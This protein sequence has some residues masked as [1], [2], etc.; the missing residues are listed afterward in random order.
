M[1]TLVWLP[2]TIGQLV[3]RPLS[4]T[5]QATSTSNPTSQSR[6]QESEFREGRRMIEETAAVYKSCKSYQ[7]EGEVVRIDDMKSG[8]RTTQKSFKTAFIRPDRF[9]FEHRELDTSLRRS[10]IFSNGTDVRTWWSHQPGEMKQDNRK[11]A[12]A[13]TLWG[14]GA[15]VFNMAAL[16]VPDE[17]DG[18]NFKRLENI[19]FSDQESSRGVLYNIIDANDGPLTSMRIWINADTKLVCKV[20]EK[21]TF[22]RWP[23]EQ[24]T[25][26]KPKINVD[27]PAEDLEFNAP[28]E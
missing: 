4:T 20:L 5:R 6:E 28:K 19:R 15:N 22:P 13:L 17:L 16:L 24:T 21:N 27:I 14:A 1:A 8:R 9:R 12:I 23:T 3:L 25:T 7:D 11:T 10:I 26:Y 18:M 2:N